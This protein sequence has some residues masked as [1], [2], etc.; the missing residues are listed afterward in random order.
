MP[1][2]LKEHIA[3]VEQHFVVDGAPADLAADVARLEALGFAPAITEIAAQSRH[4]ILRVARVF[5]EVGEHFRIRDLV[6]KAAAIG[7]LDTYDRLAI[8]H[9]VNQLAAAQAA[10][11]R[12]AI[13]GES[14]QPWS[15]APWLERFG[16]RLRRVE[17]TVDAV[18][19]RFPLTIA[20]LSVVAGQLSELAAPAAPSAST[21]T[22]HQSDP[23]KSAPSESLPFRR[24]WRQPRS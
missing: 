19:D 12:E 15:L 7:A 1:A 18:L 23:A 11:T 3:E 4:P 13:G 17:T 9:A 21:S 8:G 6:A 20:Q 10:F 5:F 2:R 22:G 14:G 24:F 16:A